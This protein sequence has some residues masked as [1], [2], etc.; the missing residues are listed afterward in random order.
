M[1]EKPIKLIIFGTG[2]FARLAKYYFNERGGYEVVAFVPIPDTWVDRDAA[3]E[4]LPML[5]FDDIRVTREVSAYR[6]FL[7]LD[8]RNDNRIRAHWADRI[9]DMGY[10]L[11]TYIDPSA[12]V[13]ADFRVGANTLVMD[14]AGA[15]P[16]VKIGRNTVIGARTR[17]GFG[18]TVGDHCWLSG[19]I[20]GESVQVGAMATIGQ[21]ATIAPGTT[22]GAGCV[23]G[24]GTL[25]R[26]SL[27]KNEVVAA[28]GATASRVPSHRL[29][30][31]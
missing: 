28:T 18:T 26:T 22:I 21:N 30:R 15:H 25:V 12:D 8:S 3:D 23:I 24:P 29:R 11:E 20:L 1:I 16:Y 10:K 13:P 14:S 17:L 9:A 4:T 27:A 2:R 5:E 6:G 31:L 19:A 7:A